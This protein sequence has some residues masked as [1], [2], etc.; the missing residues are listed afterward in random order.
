[1]DLGDRVFVGAGDDF[2][3]VV[4][5][6]LENANNQAIK[7]D[8]KMNPVSVLEFATNGGMHGLRLHN[9]QA[10]GPA[11]VLMAVMDIR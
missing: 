1:M 5:L 6:D 3:K 10:Q 7:Q 2:A 8:F 4:N 11:V 9:V